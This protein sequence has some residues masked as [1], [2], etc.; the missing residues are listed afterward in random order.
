MPTKPTKPET[1]QGYQAGTSTGTE[2]MNEQ[3]IQKELGT[4]QQDFGTVAKKFTNSASLQQ[5]CTSVQKELESFNKYYPKNVEGAQTEVTKL[6]KV[7]SDLTNPSKVTGILKDVKPESYKPLVQHFQ[8]LSNCFKSIS[9]GTSPLGKDSSVQTLTSD[10]SKVITN[11]S[12]P[13]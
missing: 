8:R 3:Q 6:D 10:I 9:K 12:K 13:H 7:I 2:T 1:T 4:L 5:I 11:L